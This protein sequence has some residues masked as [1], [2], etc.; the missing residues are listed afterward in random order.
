MV[1]FNHDN[2]IP[3]A[4]SNP[5]P[6]AN[7][8]AERVRHYFDQHPEAA[9]EEFLLHALRMEMLFREQRETRNGAGTV[10]RE[11]EWTNRRSTARPAKS[12]EDVENQAWLAERLAVIH[13]ERHGLWPKLRTFLFGNLLGWLL[14]LRP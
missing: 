1:A 11:G 2:R 9:R 3:S 13:H 6:P 7:R 4:R 8:L 14:G 5:V 10:H 12:E